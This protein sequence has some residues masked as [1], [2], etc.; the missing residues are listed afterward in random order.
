MARAHSDP[1]GEETC[2][3]FRCMADLRGRTM[4]GGYCA[5]R[6]CKDRIQTLQA[7]VGALERALAE[8]KVEPK[9]VRLTIT[10]NATRNGHPSRSVFGLLIEGQVI[11]ASTCSKSNKRSV[12]REAKERCEAWGWTLTDV[13]DKF[14][15]RKVVR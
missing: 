12:I 5:D 10:A 14:Q 6:R 15:G 4:S 9:R 3:Q 7:R 11:V 13:Y 8:K 2:P 1:C